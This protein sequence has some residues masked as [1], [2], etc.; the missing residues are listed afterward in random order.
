M[1]NVLLIFFFSGIEMGFIE[2]EELFCVLDYVQTQTRL[3]SCL[4]Y[5]FTKIFTFQMMTMFLNRLYFPKM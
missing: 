4:L 5:V 1:I 3:C 2:K